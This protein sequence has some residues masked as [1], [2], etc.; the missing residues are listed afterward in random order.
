MPRDDAAVPSSASA[1][2]PEVRVAADEARVD[3]GSSNGRGLFYE[4]ELWRS[5]LLTTSVEVDSNCSFVQGG[6]VNPLSPPGKIVLG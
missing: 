6:L 3:D 5:D 4:I 1:G 2:K